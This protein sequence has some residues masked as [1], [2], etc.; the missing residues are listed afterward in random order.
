MRITITILALFGIMSL[1]GCQ[2]KEERGPTQE[3]ETAAQISQPSPE[4]NQQQ[5]QPTT[6]PTPPTPP[7]TETFEGSP[8]LSLFP[9]VADFQPEPDDSERLPYWRTFMEHIQKTSG[10]RIVSKEPTNN[11]LQIKSLDSIDSVA[12][13]APIAVEPGVSYDISLKFKGEMPAGGRAGI[14]ALEFSEFLWIG[15]QFTE[16]Q[17]RQYQV[18]VIKGKDLESSAEWQEHS[19]S[20]TVG[21]KTKMIHL[22][23]YRDAEDGKE[24]V[25]FDDIA[26]TAANEIN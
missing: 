24:A 15:D 8:Q 17:T 6:P 12:F 1:L 21:P 22:V 23:F 26:I 13:F 5:D 14:A 10:V 2:S 7:I 11:A 20:F 19:H 9:R 3:K 16:S 25:F 4:K 18:G